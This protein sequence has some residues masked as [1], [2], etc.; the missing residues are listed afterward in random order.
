MDSEFRS[1]GYIKTVLSDIG[2]GVKNPKRGGSLYFQGE[3]YNH[4]ELLTNTLKSQKPE[5]VIL[6]PWLAENYYYIIEAKRNHKDLKIALQEDQRYCDQINQEYQEDYARF[7]TGIA[8]TPD[9]TFLVV[10][11]FWDGKNWKEVSIN[12]H[13][14]TGFYLENNAK[15]F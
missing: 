12:N 9:A 6:I 10:T 8:G 15:I 2:W 13:L 3:F 4:D 5:N 11:S 14:A 1:Y 7:A